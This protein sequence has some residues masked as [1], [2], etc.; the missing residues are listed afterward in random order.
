MVSNT[1]STY[2]LVIGHKA[3]AA[4]ARVVRHQAF[5]VESKLFSAHDEQD[6]Y[7]LTA[8][9]VAVVHTESATPVAA[10]RLIRS[11]GVVP[12]PAE[13]YTPPLFPDYPPDTIGEISRFC[14]SRSL[15]ESA[16]V[17][18]AAE[19]VKILNALVTGSF[20]A[21][22][23]A[24]IKYWCAMLERSLIQKLSQLGV[25]WAGQAGPYEAKGL[26]YVVTGS[27]A[28]MREG[29]EQFRVSKP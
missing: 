2:E 10:M 22:S 14:I 3:A 8:V 27:V 4:M 11:E 19:R 25:E 17:A 28:E 26:R 1:Q 7:D 21:A 15:C 20:D 5:C 18:T 12:L 16:R 6:R 9:H 24:G 23:I 29:A 13:L